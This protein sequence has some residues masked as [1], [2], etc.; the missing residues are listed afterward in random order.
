MFMDTEAKYSFQDVTASLVIM[1]F[2]RCPPKNDPSYVKKYAASSGHEENCTCSLKMAPKKG[3]IE[4]K[5]GL[6]A[7]MATGKLAS[8]KVMVVL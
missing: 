1:S 5:Y 6:F 8:M 2:E 4:K 3:V 7:T